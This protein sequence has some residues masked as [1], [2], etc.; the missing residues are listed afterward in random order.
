MNS[1]MRILITLLVVTII[2]ICLISLKHDVHYTSATSSSQL[3]SSTVNFAK[4]ENSSFGMKMDYPADWKK[5]EDNRGS[6]FR[7][8]NESMNIRV[9]SLPFQNQTLDQ[10]T[11]RQINLTAQQF[12]AQKI[13]QS[14][15][16]VIGNNYSAHKLLFTFPEEP[17]DPKGTN[18]KELQLWMTNNSRAYILS[19][20]TTNDSFDIYLPVV[21]KMIESFRITPVTTR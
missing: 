3:I 11:T 21:Q 18:L 17:S 14:N 4:Y 20:F 16:T 10:L 5:A 2:S 1:A 9:E 8:G 7:N 19:Y 13:L 6:W 12:P 15:A